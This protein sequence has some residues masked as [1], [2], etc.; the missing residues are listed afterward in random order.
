MT[1]P[2]LRGAGAYLD[3]PTTFRRIGPAVF[4]LEEVGRRMALRGPQWLLARSLT[5]ERTR[6][7]FSHLAGR[8]LDLGLMK[9]DKTRGHVNQATGAAQQFLAEYPEH[10]PTIRAQSPVDPYKPTGAVLDDWLRFI[11][12]HAGT[13]GQPRFGYNY[14]TLK[15]YLT[16]KYGGRAR[17]GGGGDNEFEIVLRLVAQ[18]QN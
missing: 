11:G 18:F 3:A 2:T 5:E 8:A 12:E 13:Y 4:E 10:R 1:Y 16:K 15:T 17:G 6:G 7:R 14:D 9:T